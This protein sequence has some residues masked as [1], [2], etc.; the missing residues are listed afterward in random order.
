[1]EKKGQIQNRREDLR[2]WDLREREAIKKERWVLRICMIHD[3]F[4]LGVDEA[5]ETRS[6]GCGMKTKRRKA[7]VLSFLNTL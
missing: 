5:E 4:W 7:L 1:M 2:V 3:W 6:E